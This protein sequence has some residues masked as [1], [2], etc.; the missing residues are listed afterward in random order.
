M[1]RAVATRFEVIRL[2][3]LHNTESRK[4]LDF[5]PSEIVSDKR[6]DAFA[7]FAA[8]FASFHH[9]TVGG[10]TGRLIGSHMFSYQAPR[11]SFGAP[12]KWSGET[13]QTVL[14]AT[15]LSDWVTS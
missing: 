9:T 1:T 8:I 2:N 15:T 14:V 4:I 3:A 12:K 13:G 7:L 11:N 6:T 5:R 10:T